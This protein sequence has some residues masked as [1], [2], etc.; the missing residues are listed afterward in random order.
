[1]RISPNI[2]RLKKARQGFSLI[3][4]L[5]VCALLSVLGTVLYATF[6][7]GVNLW[8][9][10]QTDRGEFR[11]IFF[12]ERLSQDLRS[13]LPLSSKKIRGKASEFEFYTLLRG[14]DLGLKETASAL[15]FPCRVRYYFD[16]TSRQIFREVQSY[17]QILTDSKERLKTTVVL[18]GA[19]RVEWMF[20]GRNKKAAILWQKTWEKDYLP[21]AVKLSIEYQGQKHLFMRTI[22]IPG[23]GRREP[24]LQIA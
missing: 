9:R 8:K 3:E 12:A 19:Q 20:M 4:L 17:S 6:Y 10:A 7:Q 24:A 14:S 23:G 22:S 13:A 1:M 5:V 18:Q 21:N 15:Q 16:G 2:P 11:D